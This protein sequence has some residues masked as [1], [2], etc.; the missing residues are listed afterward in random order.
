MGRSAAGRI[1]RGGVTWDA[2]TGMKVVGRRLRADGERVNLFTTD[3]DQY[4]PQR[5]MRAPGPDGVHWRP[6]AG[7]AHAVNVTVSVLY[8]FDELRPV[9]LD[10]MSM[11]S[12]GGEVGFTNGA[13]GTWGEATWGVGQWGGVPTIGAS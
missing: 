9:P 6:G 5:H 12:G 7:P 11:A 3:P 2:R 10:Q 8:N 1:N 4:N 13:S